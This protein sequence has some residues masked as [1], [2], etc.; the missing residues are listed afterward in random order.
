MTY[1]ELLRITLPTDQL[2]EP[3]V[4]V[5]P[6][7]IE[8]QS[9]WFAGY[10][11]GEQI[12]NHGHQIK[13]ISPGE[14]NR[15]AGPDFI[16]ATVEIDGERH[17]G[18]IELDLNARNW[19]LHKHSENPS[20]DD[21]ILHVVLHDDGP[22]YFTKTSSHREVPRV[23]LSE[24]SVDLALGRPRLA[25]ALARPGICLTPLAQM[26]ED[27]V[28]SLLKEAALHRASQKAS[29][30]QQQG[31]WHSPA[32]ALWEAIADSLGFSTNRLPMRLLAQRLPIATLKKFPPAE[33]EALLFGSAGFLAPSLHEGA[34]EDSRDY[35]EGLWKHWWKHRSEFEFAPERQLAWSTRATR[36]GNHP[37]R[38][39]A[40]LAAVACDWA[41]I[42]RFAK[43][44]S[45]FFELTEALSELS[46]PF[47][48]FHHTLRSERTE[49]RLR[50]FGLSR[51]NEFL[52]NTLYPIELEHQWSS[53]AKLRASAPNQKVK[54]CCERLFGSLTKAKPHLN[55]A[56]KHQ[57]LMQIYLDFCLEDLSD[58]ADCPFPAQL[59][60][61]ES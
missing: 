24:D 9:R 1:A 8:V 34:P 45:P 56:W 2:C 16:G 55:R 17:H 53:Y 40:A 15:G 50:I 3:T 25:Q 37:Q 35:L 21:V 33:I 52:I 49:K 44:P 42:E 48:D 22:T 39:L 10:F 5:L 14:W 4:A 19:D 26:S 51:I 43:S 28:H 36:P 59:L 29:R 41:K 27:A 61:W 54:R 13:I 47:W 57:A 38:R 58:C 32:Q 31:E 60:Q 7:E 23:C 46:H 6:D 18:P 20:F 12:D 11:S 30:Y